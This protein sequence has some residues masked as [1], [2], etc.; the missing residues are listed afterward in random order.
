MRGGGGGCGPFRGGRSSPDR[1]ERPC[2][3]GGGDDRVSPGAAWRRPSLRTRRWRRVRGLR[4]SAGAWWSLLE[5]IMS[6]VGS[7]P[8]AEL[9]P[10]YGALARDLPLLSS[11]AAIAAP[12][13]ARCVP[14]ELSAW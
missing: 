4:G 3:G 10:N 2:A 9:I 7:V 14:A 1:R 8:C 13:P 11:V 5:R 12:A 6:V